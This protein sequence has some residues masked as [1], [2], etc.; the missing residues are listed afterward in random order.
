MS[1]LPE[2][3]EDRVS[4]SRL[5]LVGV[6]IGDGFGERFFGPDHLV[7]ER[8]EGRKLPRAPWQLWR[9]AGRAMFNGGSFGNGGAMRA[10][11]I[12]AYFAEDLERV[13]VE[14]RLSAEVTHAHLL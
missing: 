8:I 12:G 3:H 4:R 10:T 2:D 6:A 1:D 7:M 13:A 5:S 11:P 9:S 14:G